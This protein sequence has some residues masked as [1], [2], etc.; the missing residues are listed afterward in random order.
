MISGFAF[1]IRTAARGL[2]VLVLWFDARD[3]NRTQ[4][5]DARGGDDWM[6]IPELLLI[7]PQWLRGKPGRDVS[8]GHGEA[9]GGEKSAVAGCRRRG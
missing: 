5:G 1:S 2:K 3:A 6:R 4:K 9:V 7:A 8:Q